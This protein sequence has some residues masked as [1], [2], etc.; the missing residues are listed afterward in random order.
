MNNNIDTLFRDL[1]LAYE[2]R[3]LDTIFNL[4]HPYNDLFNM[5]KDQLRN[6]LS[7]YELQVNFEDVT[8]LQQD[9]DTQVIR[10]SQTTKKKV[11]PEF[12]DN[13]IDMVMVLKPH[14][15]TLKILST[16]SISTEFLQ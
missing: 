6:V 13:I 4:H 9:N 12:R 5:G 14:N 15:N 7:N 2:E 10:I 16:A 11:G 3:N 1:S 8:I